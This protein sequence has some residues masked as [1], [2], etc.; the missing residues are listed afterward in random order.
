M[1]ASYPA[2]IST[3]KNTT[4]YLG[5]AS[6][7]DETH[8]S[9]DTTTHSNPTSSLPNEFEL[10]RL[11]STLSNSSCSNTSSKSQNS[12]CHSS[13]ESNLTSNSMSHSCSP[14]HDSRSNSSVSNPYGRP[15]SH[16]RNS[17]NSVS[18]SE[19]SHN[20]LEVNSNDLG[21]GW[22]LKLFF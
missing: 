13:H 12:S 22:F 21:F 19:I 10:P 11:H 15:L 8:H 18:E 17:Q 6:T 4:S 3:N 5:S 1:L 20:H 2:A 14:T 7:Q 9:T 16:S